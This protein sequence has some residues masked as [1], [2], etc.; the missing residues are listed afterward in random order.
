MTK[1]EKFRIT[2][3]YTLKQLSALCG[4]AITTMY[5]AEKGE[6]VNNRNK[7]KI[8]KALS[9]YDKRIKFFE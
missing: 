1:L 4:V 2:N 6:N 9:K 5:R 8:Q 7:Y 3:N